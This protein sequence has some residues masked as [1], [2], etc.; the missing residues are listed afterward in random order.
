ML[1]LLFALG[2]LGGWA[3]HRRAG[4]PFA[5]FAVMAL[6]V[7]VVAMVKLGNPG[8]D[9]TGLQVNYWGNLFVPLALSLWP[10]SAILLPEV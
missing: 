8:I 3:A 4:R 5:L 7:P 6:V 10:V 9:A 2:V 1:P